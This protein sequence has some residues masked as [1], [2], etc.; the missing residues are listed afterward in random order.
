M[1]MPFTIACENKLMN[2]SLRSFQASTFS[3]IDINRN[4][5]RSSLPFPCIR[6][7][8]VLYTLIM[9][10]QLYCFLIDVLTEIWFKMYFLYQKW[11]ILIHTLIT[12]SYKAFPCVPFWFLVFLVMRIAYDPICISN[13]NLKMGHFWYKLV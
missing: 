11:E 7:F 4:I 9:Y 10:V 13:H 6:Q 3:K 2:K 12:H 5:V 1:P 8:K